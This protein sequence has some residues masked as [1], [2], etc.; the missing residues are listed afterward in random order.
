VAPKSD[1]KFRICLLEHPS[2]VGIGDAVEVLGTVVG[3][4]CVRVVNADNVHFFVLEDL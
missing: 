4:R 2:V 3:E 1:D